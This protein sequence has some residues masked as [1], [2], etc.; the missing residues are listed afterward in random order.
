M[1]CDFCVFLVEYHDDL[2]EVWICQTGISLQ[3]SCVNMTTVLQCLAIGKSCQEDNFV[4]PCH[5]M[6]DQPRT[7]SIVKARP[8]ALGR[9][10]APP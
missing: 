5:Q 2:S 8:Q 4:L 1:R 9:V 7:T 3:R 10:T 6:S